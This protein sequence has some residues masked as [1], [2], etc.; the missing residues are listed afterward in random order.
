MR[1]IIQEARAIAARGIAAGLLNHQGAGQERA[2][3]QALAFTRAAVAR[4]AQQGLVKVA[5]DNP[6]ATEAE[7]RAKRRRYTRHWNRHYRERLYARR[8]RRPLVSRG[9]FP[10][11]E[12]GY[13]EYCR[14]YRKAWYAVP[15]NRERQLRSVR[16]WH[17]AQSTHKA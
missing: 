2:K 7:L 16:A 9:E 4:L 1:S 14:A 10:D 5:A 3:E 12:E 15:A 8:G 13:R 11:T 6:D 17:A